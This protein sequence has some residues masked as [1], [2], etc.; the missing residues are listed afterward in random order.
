MIHF[1]KLAVHLGPGIDG[2]DWD[3]RREIIRSL[4]ERIE[5]GR[6]GIAMVFRLPQGIA[7]SNKNP[8]MVAL[9]RA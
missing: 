5:I 4:V 8:I 7:V 6:A 9:S 2:S 3:R 1:Q